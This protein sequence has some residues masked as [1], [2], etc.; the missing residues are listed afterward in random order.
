[1]LR[2]VVVI[3]RDAAISPSAAD[4]FAPAGGRGW[5][6]LF[7]S[8]RCAVWIAVSG[9][10]TLSGAPLPGGCVVGMTWKPPRHAAELTSAEG[11]FV[12]VHED[13][14]D[15][16]ITVYRDPSGRIAAYRAET[17]SAFLVGSHAEDLLACGCRGMVFDWD[18]LTFYV[19]NSF[20]PERRTGIE[21]VKEI[22][23][24][25]TV[26]Y[27]CGT[28]VTSL[29]WEPSQH[30]G[31][32][33]RHPGQAREAF[34]V[35]AETAAHAWA[36]GY[37]RVTLDLSGGLDS[38]I[39]LGLLAS[40]PARPEIICINFSTEHAESDERAF[41]RQSAARH[42][43]RLIE[44]DLEHVLPNYRTAA[45]MP[46][47]PRPT[48]AALRIGFDAAAMEVTRELGA[49]AY[50]TGRGGDH[51]FF[52]SVPSEAAV[53]DLWVRKNALTWLRSAYVAARLTGK[54]LM[55]VLGQA[56]A[57]PNARERRRNIVSG[58][59]EFLVRDAV[60]ALPLD[61]LTH[62][63]LMLA[64]RRAPP[65]KLIQV[66]NIIELQNHYNRVGRAELAD[67]AHPFISQPCLEAAMRTP[68]YFFADP[69]TKRRLQR[70]TFKDL[71]P[72]AVYRRRTK[73]GTTS[74]V[75]RTL[76]RNIPYIRELLLEG[77]LVARGVLDRGLLSAKLS[78]T[79]LLDGRHVASLVE[80][81]T[82]QM[83]LEQARPCLEA[84]RRAPEA[85]RF[86]AS[87]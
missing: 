19:L 16:A 36:G 45:P 49:G 21:G 48:V 69:Q 85:A 72:E 37:S 22:L 87:S 20:V 54:P 65:A 52:H 47:Q 76:S 28:A 82:V 55:S 75:V 44:R 42:G 81:L 59:N 80:C 86:S 77:E 51:L 1:M 2:Y 8:Q 25:E 7:A 10:A 32:P 30:Y 27:A 74:H 56:F 34:R 41:A 58:Q 6:L 66:R 64:A 62:P 68:T 26:R 46:L 63:W 9:A 35:A 71:L 61:D 3:S 33:F 23:P 18:Y 15:G 70:E 83:W 39:M 38:S 40:A 73:G 14:R 50:F 24:G 31:R 17:D 4:A 29:A 53:D 84:A 67:E 11:A 60:E 5:R 79:S 13:E 57:Q 43:A 78:P 12:G